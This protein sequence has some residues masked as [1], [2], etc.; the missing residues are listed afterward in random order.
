MHKSPRLVEWTPALV[1]GLP[2]FRLMIVLAAPGCAWY[3]ASG[4]C[5]NCSFP[6]SMGTGQPVSADEF[7]AQLENAFDHIPTST[8]SDAPIAV[9][10]F[11]SGSFFN[12]EEVDVES[13]RRLLMRTARLPRIRRILIETRPEYLSADALN[14]AL[15]A[16]GNVPLEIAIGLETASNEIR[17]KRIRKGFTWRQFEQ[18]ARLIAGTKA[19]LFVYVLVK[20]MNTSEAEA[21]ADAKD[22]AEKVFALAKELNLPTRIGLEPC[23]VAPD[24]DLDKIFQAGKYRPPWLW[25][26]L[27]VTRHVAPLG[28]VHVGLSDENLQPARE[29][30][31]CDLCSGKVR[32][33]LAKFNLSQNPAALDELDCACKGEWKKVLADS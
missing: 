24:T 28:P 27:E 16:T 10:L 15:V 3:E 5:T 30:H 23:F 19:Q 14:R 12:V 17:N 8:G 22:T 25:T 18:S 4:G 9:D 21:M 29:A 13:Q 1:D 6:Q 33:A 31:N 2:G 32:A 26:L 20:P 11:V 7:V